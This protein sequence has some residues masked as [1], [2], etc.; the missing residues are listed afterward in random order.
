[1]KLYIQKILFYFLVWCFR[2]AR[3]VGLHNP[4]KVETFLDIDH[5]YTDPLNTRF[6]A[7]ANSPQEINYNENIDPIFYDKKAYN[8]YMQESNTDIEKIWRT[9]IL[10][11]NTPRGNIIFFYD[12]Y[13]MGFSFYSDEKTIPYD[14]LNAVAMKY[15]TMYRCLD[16]FVDESVVPKGSPFI[17]LYFTEEAKKINT[18]SATNPY[19][20]MRKEN[21]NMKAQLQP[22]QINK[23]LNPDEKKAPEKMKNK[24]LYLG[25]INNAFILQPA[26]KTRKVL[27]KFTSPLLETIK[28]ES[29]VQ[30]ETLSY[31][32]FKKSLVNITQMPPNEAPIITIEGSIE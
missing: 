18:P 5:K 31:R 17:K 2:I 13:K 16:F 32:D 29:G 22:P 7:I 10:L 24:F 23:S 14:I 8:S 3:Y 25:K 6:S 11:E 27:A 28:M 4:K 1:M 21:P 15:V 26:P 20:R 12:A 9:R 30:R 19:A